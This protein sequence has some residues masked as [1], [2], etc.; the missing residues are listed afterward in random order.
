MASWPPA[1]KVWEPTCPTGGRRISYTRSGGKRGIGGGGAVP[2]LEEPNRADGAT[3]FANGVNGPLR[4]Q[5]IVRNYIS[6]PFGDF[7]LPL[8]KYFWNISKVSKVSKV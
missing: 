1:E 3:D 7:D 5:L 4:L 8:L 6:S 2:P